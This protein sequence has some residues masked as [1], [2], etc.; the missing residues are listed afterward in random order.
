M[1]WFNRFIEQ[2]RLTNQTPPTHTHTHTH[3]HQDSSLVVRWGT[4][5]C[6]QLE[7]ETKQDDDPAMIKTIFHTQLYVLVRR[8]CVSIN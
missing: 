4:H 6:P 8:L 3:T 2:I 5:S 7:D 1:N